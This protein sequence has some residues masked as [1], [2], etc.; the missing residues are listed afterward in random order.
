MA[1]KK[2]GSWEVKKIEE[3]WWN[4]KNFWTRIKELL[5]KK[6][7]RD[8]E[9]FVYTNEGS[10]NEILEV[11]EDYLKTWKVTIY[12]K[13]KRPDFSF[14]YGTKG[15]MADMIEEEKKSETNI[16]E[17]PIIREEELVEVIKKYEEW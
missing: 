16:M 9:V 3:T 2:K 11:S 7:E 17:F 1:T 8:D 12:Q 6:K 10:R 14:W 4:G 13:S 15:K 5:G